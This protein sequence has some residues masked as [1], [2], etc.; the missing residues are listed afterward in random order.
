MLSQSAHHLKTAVSETNVVLSSSILTPVST[1]NYIIVGIAL[2]LIEIM[3]RYKQTI[4]V[5]HN[6][7][8]T[9]Y[10][11]WNP[12]EPYNIKMDSGYIEIGLQLTGLW[13]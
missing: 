13:E 8:D 12:L 7:V 1:K 6:I 4:L 5:S 9:C 2:K 11:A 10:S 3:H